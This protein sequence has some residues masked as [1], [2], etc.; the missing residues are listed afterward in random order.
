[1]KE[2]SAA[3]LLTSIEVANVCR[4]QNRQARENS[5]LGPLCIFSAGV[6]CLIAA[7]LIAMQSGFVPGNQA[8]DT[9]DPVEWN[10]ENVE[11]SDLDACAS[12]VEI[13]TGNGIIRRLA[14]GEYRN[15]ASR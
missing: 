13:H 9:S 15:T 5:I 7:A 12:Q 8:A 4:R 14:N 3:S 2:T 11:E 6:L 1:M 10:C